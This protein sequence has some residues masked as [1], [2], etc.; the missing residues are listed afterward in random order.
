M[1]LWKAELLGRNVS[2]SLFPVQNIIGVFSLRQT[3][4]VAGPAPTFPSCTT[5]NLGGW[6]VF[7]GKR[8]ANVGFEPIADPSLS[9]KMPTPLKLNIS[10][11]QNSEKEMLLDQLDFTKSMSW[12]FCDLSPNQARNCHHKQANTSDLECKAFDL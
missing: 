6:V 4:K 7:W 11:V 10:Q 2:K 8:L 1:F 3:K 9:S 5:D 12:C